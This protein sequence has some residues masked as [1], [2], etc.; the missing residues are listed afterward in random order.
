M[1]NEFA[2]T[3]APLEQFSSDPSVFVGQ[4]NHWAASKNSL[5]LAA[6]FTS[7]ARAA[8]LVASGATP[9]L[10][11]PTAVPTVCVPW[12]TSSAVSDVSRDTSV[13][14]MNQKA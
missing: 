13:S 4:R 7:N 8:I 12:P 2:S 5:L 14:G 10:F 6:P 9:M 1:L 3:S 11:P